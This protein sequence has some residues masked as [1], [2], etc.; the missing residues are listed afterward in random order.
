MPSVVFKLL[1]VVSVC[2]ISLFLT[3]ETVIDDYFNLDLLVFVMV[4]FIS[5]DRIC[6]LASHESVDHF[7]SWLILIMFSSCNKHSNSRSL[8]CIA[9]GIHFSDIVLKCILT[10][11][12]K[13]FTFHDSG[14][15]LQRI[16]NI[17]LDIPEECAS[18]P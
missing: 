18:L 4:H 15:L 3:S 17:N 12:T 10:T 14:L 7:L 5:E 16:P 13:C 1:T 9:L 2:I 6:K 11:V 8:A